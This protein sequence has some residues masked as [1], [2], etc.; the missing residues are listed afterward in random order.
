[1]RASPIHGQEG[2]LSQKDSPRT[3]QGQSFKERQPTPALATQAEHTR[4][5]PVG[6]EKTR[7]RSLAVC[8]GISGLRNWAEGF[9][10]LSEAGSPARVPRVTHGTRPAPPPFIT[11]GTFYRDSLKYFPEKITGTK[12]LCKQSVK[13]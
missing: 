10:C 7:R 3:R 4:R 9:C 5:E 8:C 11:P 12:T 6:N 2:S 1:M 13:K